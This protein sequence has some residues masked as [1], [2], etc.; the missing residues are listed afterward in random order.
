MEKHCPRCGNE[1]VV[2]QITFEPGLAGEVLNPAIQLFCEKCN[3]LF[4]KSI[5]VSEFEE[6]RMVKINA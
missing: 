6:I 1:E 2:R 5:S 4:R 3:L